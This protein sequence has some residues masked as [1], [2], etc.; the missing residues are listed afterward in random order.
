MQDNNS[1]QN[2]SD[3]EVIDL[4]IEGIMA[5]KG[6]NAPTEEIEQSIHD[7]LKTKLLTEIDRSLVGELPDDKLN[8]LYAQAEAGGGSLDPA[9]IADAIEQAGLDTAAITGVTMKRFRNLYLG[10]PADADDDDE[11]SDSAAM[12]EAPADAMSTPETPN[13]E[14]S[15][16]EFETNLF[17]AAR[18]M[19]E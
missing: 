19:G 3:E 15:Q 8:E 13:N 18:E 6:V 4:F 17:A 1:I 10:R 12:N 7:E 9:L 16:P 11:I 2:L 14:F 5:E